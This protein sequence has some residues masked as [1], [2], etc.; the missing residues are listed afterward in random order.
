MLIVIYGIAGH[1]SRTRLLPALRGWRWRIIGVGRRMRASTKIY[2]YY[3]AK[4]FSEIRKEIERA[5]RTLIYLA[6]PPQELENILKDL[7]IILQ[8]TATVRIA[9][10]KPFG[11]GYNNAIKLYNILLSMFT[12]K[13]IYFV[14][15]YL[16]KSELAIEYPKKHILSV[17]IHLCDAQTSPEGLTQ[18]INDL[19]QSHALLLL[20]KICPELDFSTLEIITAKVNDLNV[21]C[22]F[23]S[24][25]IFIK[26][27]VC[28]GTIEKK[29][30][31]IRYYDGSKTVIKLNSLAN[32]SYS[33]SSPYQRVFK[34]LRGGDHHNFPNFNDILI[35][36]KVTENIQIAATRKIFP[37]PLLQDYSEY[38]S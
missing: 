17:A 4:E 34:A 21:F 10:E 26:I 22:V 7:K 27:N 16:H 8:T 35:S 28:K 18:V 19:F 30:V 6:V 2:T 3:V 32:Q 33:T 23:F 12:E 20:K 15:H 25:Y 29:Y 5:S 24:P 14:D 38:Q 11:L 13:Q 9:I 1:L 37:W 36:W 31:K